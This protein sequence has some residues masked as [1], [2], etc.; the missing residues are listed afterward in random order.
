ILRGRRAGSRLGRVVVTACFVLG[1]VLFRAP[2]LEH[3]WGYYGAMFTWSPP[4]RWILLQA[5]FF[6][7]LA[8]AWFFAFVAPSSVA[9][10]LART[11]P[12]HAG[13]RLA[14]GAGFAAFLLV[15]L[16]RA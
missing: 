1:G 9:S 10:A 13:W 4:E 5:D 14:R 3:A 16:A 12:A 2:T 15:T 11:V 6:V 7:T 8:V